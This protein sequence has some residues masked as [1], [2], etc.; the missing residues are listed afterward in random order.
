MF[1]SNSRKECIVIYNIATSI[2][3]AKV[4]KLWAFA[5]IS[6]FGIFIFMQQSINPYSFCGFSYPFALSFS[7]SF[8]LHSLCLHPPLTHPHLIAHSTI[9]HYSLQHHYS[10]YGFCRHLLNFRHL[11]SHSFRQY[12]F[13]SPVFLSWNYLRLLSYFCL[14]LIK[15]GTKNWN[16]YL[17][18]IV[19]FIVH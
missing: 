6:I 1:I 10:Y 12:F 14:L 13:L 15:S 5:E 7:L 3:Y 16:M 18:K 8:F 11:G 2:K 4:E 9:F 19:F 17:Q